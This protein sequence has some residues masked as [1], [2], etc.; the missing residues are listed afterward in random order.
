MIRRP[1][2]ST[3]TD[4]LFPYT[5]LFRSSKTGNIR[6]NSRFTLADDLILTVDPSFQYVRANG[7]G[8]ATAREGFR[9]INPGSGVTNAVG[10][11]GGSPYFG[12]DVNGDGD[13]L[14]SIRVLAPSETNTRRYGLIASLRYNF[15]EDQSIRVAYSLDYA[16][17][18]QTGEIEFLRNDGQPLHAFPQEG[19][20][21]RDA[22]GSGI[23][24]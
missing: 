21:L 15:S 11:L 13:L 17:H 10:Y 22:T 16:R 8:T 2:I 14:D 23:G 6:I 5:T 4:T 3:R 9:D 20:P 12:Y 1:P 19:N 7:G 24:R 18:R